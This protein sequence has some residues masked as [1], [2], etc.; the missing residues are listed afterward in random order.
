VAGEIGHIHSVGT[1]TPPFDQAGHAIGLALATVANLVGPQRIIVSG[2]GLAAYDL[3]A[4]HVRQAFAAHAFGT[5]GRC[6]LVIRPLPFEEWA[7]GAAAV[8]IQA[9]FS[10]SHH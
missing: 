9:L 6:A 7:R 2:E 1:R 4:D 8:S 3:F 5:A 10:P